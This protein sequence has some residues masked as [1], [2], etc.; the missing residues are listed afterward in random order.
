MITVKT[1][2]ESKAKVTKRTVLSI[3]IGFLI[4]GSFL[5]VC[6][7]S[8]LAYLLGIGFGWSLFS[9]LYLYLLTVNLIR[10][11]VDRK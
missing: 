4:L 6:F 3:A 11:A 8:L 10:F 1:E 7:F 9:L 5:Q 2:N